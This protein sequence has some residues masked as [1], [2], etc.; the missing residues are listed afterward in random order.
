MF[1]A[2]DNR[3]PVWAASL[4]NPPRCVNSAHRPTGMS[5][6]LHYTPSLNGRNPRF[7]DKLQLDL[8]T[9]AKSQTKPLRCTH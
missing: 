2:S 4:D 9:A 5:F 6:I 3:L 1:A 7:G 8:E